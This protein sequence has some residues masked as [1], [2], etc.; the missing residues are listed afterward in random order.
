MAA[1]SVTVIGLGAM[2]GGMARA[3]LRSDVSQMVIG[4]DRVSALM[5][6]FHEEALAVNKAP[7]AIP[8]G[9]SDAINLAKDEK[10]ENIHAVLLVL[11]NEKQCQDVCFGDGDN[12]LSLLASNKSKKSIVILHSTVTGKRQS[13]GSQQ[14]QKLSCSQNSLRY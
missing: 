13:T 2:G 9:L 12:L 4:Y 8:S 11:V 1:Y 3:V 10:S 6:E 7:T 14:Y 5:E